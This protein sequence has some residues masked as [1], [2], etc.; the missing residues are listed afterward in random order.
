[1]ANKITL[2]ILFWTVKILSVTCSSAVIL[3]NSVEL[4]ANSFYKNVN[5]GEWG[6]FIFDEGSITF[7]VEC[8]VTMSKE[9]QPVDF[10]LIAQLS[11]NRS[12]GDVTSMA[13][14][15]NLYQMG[16]L[17]AKQDIYPVPAIRL[18]EKSTEFRLNINIESGSLYSV[19]LLECPKSNLLASDLLGVPCQTKLI[20][21]NDNLRNH[22]SADME[23]IHYT[24]KGMVLVWLFIFVFWHYNWI[25]FRKFSNGLHKLV[26][27]VPNLK[28][29]HILFVWYFWDQQEKEGTI[30][31][32]VVVCVEILAVLSSSSFFSVVLLSS[33][34]WC[35][36]SPNIDRR[37]RL[38]ICLP[39]TLLF[40][41]AISCVF[42]FSRNKLIQVVFWAI[43]VFGFTLFSF[44][45][46]LMV[47]HHQKV[48]RDQS[49]FFN[50]K[51]NPLQL[52]FHTDT[53]KKQLMMKY[54]LLSKLKLVIFFFYITSVTCKV[55]WLLLLH[56]Y[57]VGILLEI[58]HILLFLIFA[59]IFHLEDFSE[60]EVVDFL[61][62]GYMCM[63]LLPYADV[64]HLSE[65]NLA[66]GLEISKKVPHQT[67]VC[68]KR[69]GIGYSVFPV[70]V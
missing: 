62:P 50:P 70:S 16:S 30:T 33:M 3:E 47:R 9:S 23:W 15:Q 25:Q 59:F 40:H 28:I 14:C 41:I 32:K 67:K 2:F 7:E 26:T 8:P 21:T 27:F 49:S 55:L 12:I 31:T 44:V 43:W 19:L 42:S 34:G 1:M 66:V 10:F 54:S 52:V 39:G 17:S 61:P 35:I 37:W 22:L 69:K 63:M 64:N 4:G 45:C 5:L 68:S 65:H 48:L 13:E 57:Y 20:L 36:M 29:V 60:F 53:R 56:P 46:L 18:S 58:Q 11:N 38:G 6:H 24:Y 51:A